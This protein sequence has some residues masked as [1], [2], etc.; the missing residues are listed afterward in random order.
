MVIQEKYQSFT[1]TDITACILGFVVT[2][3]L[4]QSAHYFPRKDVNMVKFYFIL[5]VCLMSGC[6]TET[7]TARQDVSEFKM[8]TP[9][10]PITGSVVTNGTEVAKGTTSVDPAKV[11]AVANVAA[12]GLTA[13]SPLL[14]LG[15][16]G[17]LL[18]AG[19]MAWIAR[20]AKAKA[21]LT[22]GALT[23]VTAG[24]QNFMDNGEPIAVRSL[25]TNLS[26]E[27]DQSHKDLVREL[28]P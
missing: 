1:L 24:V 13:V 6:A 21:D 26:Q 5:M 19:G 18:L 25:R 15:S 28:K 4:V 20:K 16:V 11:A 3:L 23:A 12:S 14:G 22:E 10:G 9:A 27:M 8:E 17:S 7:H 2:T